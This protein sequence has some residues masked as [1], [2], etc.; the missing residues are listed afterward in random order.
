MS[1]A[2]SASA[3]LAGGAGWTPFALERPAPA[4]MTY[5][6]CTAAITLCAFPLTILPLYFKYHTL[7]YHFDEQG[8]RMSWG[9][10][11]RREVYLTYQRIQDIHVTRD[12]FER[13]LGLGSV[14]IQTASGSATPEMTVV[15]LREYE[16]LRDY[17]YG[18]MRG[19]KEEGAP[20][21]EA[22]GSA[23][24]LEAIRAELER[25]ATALER[26]ARHG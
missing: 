22:A 4:L 6:L 14:A 13:W 12:I 2:E 25:A 17:L 1:A 7:R 16:S 11:F 10:V 15:G 5:Y 3:P 21:G 26:S 24:T 9:I 19:V 8:V 18:R 20:V 23:P